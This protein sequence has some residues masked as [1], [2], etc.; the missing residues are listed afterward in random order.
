MPGWGGHGRVKVNLC[1][2]LE[3][4]INEPVGFKVVVVFAERVYQLFGHLRRTK[5]KAQ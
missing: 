2:N 5:N 4:T 3:V 1:P